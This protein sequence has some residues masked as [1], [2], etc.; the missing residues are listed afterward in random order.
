M[1]GGRQGSAG[2]S[3]CRSAAQSRPGSV[4]P[5][6]AAATG[7]AAA[8][9]RRRR[10]CCLAERGRSRSRR[11]GQLRGVGRS[12]PVGMLIGPAS[13]RARSRPSV[14][15][16]TR[17]PGRSRKSASSACRLAWDGTP[18]PARRSARPRRAASLLSIKAIY[19]HY[20]A[21]PGVGCI[22]FPSGRRLRGV[23]WRRPSPSDGGRRRGPPITR[24]GQSVCEPA[25]GPAAP[26]RTR[27]ASSFQGRQFA[28]VGPD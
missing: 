24:A 8:A 21:V 16:L 6:P 15:R 18:H 1:A 2:V 23:D 19:V 10:C 26:R 25:A 9:G 22:I 13:G 14:P 17:A 3:G 11:G 12:L 27:P 5:A 7:R 4:P 28:A 20:A